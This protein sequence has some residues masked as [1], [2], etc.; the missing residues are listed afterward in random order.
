[1]TRRTEARQGAIPGICV[2]RFG[3]CHMQFRALPKV[4]RGPAIKSLARC[5]NDSR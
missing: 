1:M 5:K 3:D 2:M 4:K